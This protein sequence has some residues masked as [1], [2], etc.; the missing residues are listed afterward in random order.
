MEFLLPLCDRMYVLSTGE[1]LWEGPP[2]EFRRNEKVVEAYLGRGT[3][4][5]R[6]TPA[7]EGVRR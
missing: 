4:S 1:R 3:E 5:A 2:E 6:P 7:S